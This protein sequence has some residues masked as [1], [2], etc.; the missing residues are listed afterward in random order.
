MSLPADTLWN[1]F[2]DFVGSV[3]GSKEAAASNSDKHREPHAPRQP[4]TPRN[5]SDRK[6][7]GSG[8]R[9]YR[10]SGGGGSNRG[11]GGEGHSRS[12]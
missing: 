11:R 9:P 5:P 1:R 2:K 8:D 6:A 7:P 4:Y 12:R 3:I 10:R